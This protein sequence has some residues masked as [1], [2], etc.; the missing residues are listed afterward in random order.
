M[1]AVSP[2]TPIHSSNTPEPS[3]QALADLYGNKLAATA[4]LQRKVTNLLIQSLFKSDKQQL[5]S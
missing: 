2:V 3:Q 4:D 5:E 1:Q